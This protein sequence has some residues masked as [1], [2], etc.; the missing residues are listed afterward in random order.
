M[1]TQIS[2]KKLTMLQKQVKS[3]K[4]AMYSVSA[5]LSRTKHLCLDFELN[6]ENPLFKTLNEASEQYLSLA[7]SIGTMAKSLETIENEILTVSEN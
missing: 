6:C 5:Q 1:T 2:I 4:C 7:A 3:V